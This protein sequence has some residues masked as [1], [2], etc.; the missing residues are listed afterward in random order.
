MHRRDTGA[1][2]IDGRRRLLADARQGGQRR[3]HAVV[4]SA[5]GAR[6]GA[7]APAR[8]E[9][10]RRSCSSPARRAAS[11]SAR[12]SR[13]SRTC[14]MPRRRAEM[15]ARGQALLGR[16]AALGVPTVA[17]ID[18]FALGGGLELALACDYRVAVDVLR[19]DAGAAG[20]AARHSSR[21][22]RLRAR[23]ARSSA[24]RSRSISC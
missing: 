13:S 22:R 5:R 18:G 12:T 7:R 6:A 24:P 20:G 15:A 11:S 9:R 21:V 4:R 10:A 23:R 16:I 8:A 1:R 2:R 19:A 14:R 3:Q 17:A